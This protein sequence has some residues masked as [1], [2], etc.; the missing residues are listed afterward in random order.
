LGLALSLKLVRLM[1]GDIAVESTVGTGSCFTLRLPV[2][3]PAAQRDA[4]GSGRT[5]SD[6]LSAA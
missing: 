3:P 1:G 5:H 2:T 4:D 6:L